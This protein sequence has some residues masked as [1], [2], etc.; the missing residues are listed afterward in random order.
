[1]VKLAIG[2]EVAGIPTEMS[3]RNNRGGRETARSRVA[4]RHRVR[5]QRRRER[6]IAGSATAGVALTT[7]VA[8]SAAGGVAV[9]SAIADRISALAGLSERYR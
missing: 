8:I 9:A 4:M 2:P 6:I 1:M 7:M 3:R 5:P